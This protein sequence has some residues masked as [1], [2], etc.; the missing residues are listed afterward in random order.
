MRIIVDGDIIVLEFG[1]SVLRG[2][3]DVPAAV[4]EIYRWYRAGWRVVTVATSIGDQPAAP[5]LGLA[6]ERAGIPA[7]VIDASQIEPLRASLE[8]TPVLVAA[9]FGQ[10]ESD[11]SAVYLANALRASRCRLLK[12]VDGVYESDPHGSPAVLQRFSAL[13]YADALELATTPIEP[14]AVKLLD[15]YSGRAEVASIAS[16]YESVIGRFDRTAAQSAT[17][18]PTTVLILG[19]DDL[20]ANIQQ[21]AAAMPEHFHVIGTFDHLRESPAAVMDLHP[22]VVVDV[23]SD[24]DPARSLVSHFIYRGAS[25]V[26]ANLALIA[27][28]GRELNTFAARCNT[29]LRYNAAVGGSAPMMEALRREIHRGDIRSIAAVF[30]GE[31]SRILDR[32]SKGFA[33]EELL[34][35]ATTEIGAAA[36]HQELSGMRAAR[37]LCVLARHA[38]GRDPDAF[39]VEALDAESLRRA[40]N[41]PS[42]NCTLR[43]VARAWKISH[44]VFGQVRMQAL[45]TRDPLAQVQPEWNRLVITHR[46][47]R[48]LVVQGRDGHWPTTE[49]LMADLLDVRF[50]HLALSRPG[51]Q[52]AP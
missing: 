4:H 32:F 3:S 15:R 41:S 18:P 35:N 6:L 40:R 7:R 12:D 21:R 46:N 28:A 48:Q 34:L 20:G 24:V 14:K 36:V 8:Y 11:L 2:P 49:A 33:F 17:L 38:F 13:G 43:L 23:L 25:I 44:H 51:T 39:R 22:D 10:H 50:T 42:E 27:E 30:S 26:S 29:Y 52:A 9:G 19:V 47:A 5:A 45:D 37:K 16:P 1:G 31:A